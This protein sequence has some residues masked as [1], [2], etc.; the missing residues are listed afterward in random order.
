[1]SPKILYVEDN[2]VIRERVAAH[3]RA[4]GFGVIECADATDARRAFAEA[5]FAL[6]LLDVMLPDGNG[7]ALLRELRA[8]V[9][10]SVPVVIVS[11]LGEIDERVSGLDAGANDY[12]AKP[13]SLRELSARIRAALRVSSA[14]G[15]ERREPAARLRIGDGLLDCARACVVRGDGTEIALSLREFFLLRRLAEEAGLV[16][17]L[18]ELI[19][20]V[21]K[22]NPG[23]TVSQS[24]A[25]F[26]SRLRRKL[27]G[28]CEIE[29]VR[30]LGYRLAPRSRD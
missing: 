3:L 23:K 8:A 30:G 1:M 10:E 22:M 28:V 21:W 6:A 2:S 19:A 15:R 26:V 16:V 25:V 27:A 11:A 17:P 5:D 9:G 20:A 12:L 4:E 13:F 29:A 24:P 14:A 18:S 7:I